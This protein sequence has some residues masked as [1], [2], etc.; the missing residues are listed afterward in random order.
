VN[1]KI[2][3][4]TEHGIFEYDEASDSFKASDY[5]NK[6]FAGKNIR[7]LKQDD[8]GNTWFVYD[9][10]LGVLEQ[11]GK[12]TQIIYFPEL[13]NKFVSGFEHV[14]PVNKN[15]IIIGGEKGFYHINYEQYKTIKNP[16]RVLITS[17]KAINKKDSLLFG[18]YTGEVNGEMGL[19]N[20][21]AVS[22]SWNSFHFE[23]ASP[24]FAQ[25]ANIEYSYMLEGFDTKWSEF[26]RRTEKEY[27]NLSAGDYTFKVKC[28]NNL[29][30][31]S[32]V[33]AYSFTVSPPWY[34]SN[35]AYAFYIFLFGLAAYALYRRQ[36]TKFRRQQS[37][38]EEEQ[39]RL[40]YLHQ[41]ELEKNEKE[42]VK[43]RNEKLEAEITHKNS[44]LASVA[45][46]LVQKGEMLT[47]I[48]EQIEHLKKNPA[49]VRDSEEMKK[50][51]RS[52]SDEEK[53]DH[54]WEQF[55]KHFDNVHSDFFTHL[56]DKYG[57]LSPNE[58]KLSAYLRMNLST[59]EIAQLMNISVRGVEISR[60]RLRKK[61]GIPTDV[62][63]YEFLVKA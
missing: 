44:E 62:N 27:T 53:I 45:M 2:I 6:I 16:L 17:V 5:Y 32:E 35:W 21:G 25:Q 3:L 39:Q 38:H 50:I 61:L 30:N 13:T 55:T 43:L 52:L 41:L 23:Y 42:I 57:N 56:K 29:G 34:L 1:N 48:R 31:E 7:Y 10:I 51:L 47:R 58:L 36:R 4:T 22:H 54:Q 63:L 19:P 15:N 59:K 28:R 33:A 12:N 8:S 9:K 14:Y 26:S 18:G 20:R 46:H 40:Q 11:N 37:R 60:Y 24:L 49:H